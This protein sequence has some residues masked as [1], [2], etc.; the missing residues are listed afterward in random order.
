MW[1]HVFSPILALG[2]T[3]LGLWAASNPAKYRA[4][5]WRE[6]FW[7]LFHNDRAGLVAFAYF[8]IADINFFATLSMKDMLTTYCIPR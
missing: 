4:L 2:A 5:T 7:E 3:T 1:N 8:V 6:G